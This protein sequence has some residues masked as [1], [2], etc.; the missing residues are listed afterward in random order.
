MKPTENIEEFVRLEKPRVKT[1]STMDKRTLNDSFAAMD[2]TIRANKP[3]AAGMIFRSR[4]AKL[5]AAAVII[6]A[7]GLIMVYR[8]PS[9]PQQPQQTVSVAKS[10]IEMLTARSLMTAYRHGGIEAI[11]SQCDKAFEMSGQRRDTLNVKELFA[12]IEVDLERTEL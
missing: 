1:G 2:E 6:V 7:V 8:N 4:L 10:P 11:N 3:N 12:E 5:A 9:V